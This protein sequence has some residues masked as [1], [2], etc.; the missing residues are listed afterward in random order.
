MAPKTTPASRHP[1][2]A[3]AETAER[4]F[5]QYEIQESHRRKNGLLGIY[6]HRLKDQHG[7]RMRK[8]RNPFCNI[9]VEVEES[10]LGLWSNKERKR[11]SEIYPTYDWVDDDGYQNVGHWIEEAARKAGR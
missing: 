2:A 6:V 11:L 7:E 1:V 10:F 5:V 9:T 8:G 4:R 3:D